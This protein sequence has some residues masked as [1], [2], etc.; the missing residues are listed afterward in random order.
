MRTL[1]WIDQHAAG[2]ALRKPVLEDRGYAVL[3]VPTAREGLAI[4][5]AKPVEAVILDCLL[6]DMDGEALVNSIRAI[7]STL[8]IIVL[9]SLGN[10][11]ADGLA[12][13]ADATFTKARDSFSSVAAKVCELI[14]QRTQK[15]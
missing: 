3:A 4:I 15:A 10:G 5:S 1:I 7:D 9:S 13:R 6:P 8:P 12:H 11:V 14:T 2:V